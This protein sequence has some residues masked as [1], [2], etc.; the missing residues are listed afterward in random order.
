MYSV[1]FIRLNKKKSLMSQVRDLAPFD[2]SE[3]ILKINKKVSKM[4]ADG[5]PASSRKFHL[6]SPTT[7]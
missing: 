1:N 7:K 6:S 3:M 4:D 2:A 5:N